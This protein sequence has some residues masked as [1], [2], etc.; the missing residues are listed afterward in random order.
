MK[1]HRAPIKEDAKLMA[2]NSQPIFK[3]FSLSDSPVNL[4]MHFFRLVAAWWPGA[5]SAEDNTFLLI[6]S[7]NIDRFKNQF[8]SGRLSNKPLLI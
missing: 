5:Q 2:V 6:T 4:V 7:P 8:F 1:L 3:I